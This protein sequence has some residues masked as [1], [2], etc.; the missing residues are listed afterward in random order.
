MEAIIGYIIGFTVAWLL[1]RRSKRDYDPYESNIRWD[2][3]IEY[4]K[5]T[6]ERK[7]DGYIEMRRGGMVYRIPKPSGVQENSDTKI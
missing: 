3:E 4:P 1:C 6:E 2:A 5:S 7:D